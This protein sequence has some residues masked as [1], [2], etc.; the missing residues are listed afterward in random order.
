MP[1]LF[2]SSFSN[3][4]STIRLITSSFPSSI[5]TFCNL[6]GS[7]IDSK[8]VYS[9]SM[10]D[11]VSRSTVFYSTAV[12]LFYPSFFVI[13]FHSADSAAANSATKAASALL[14]ASSYFLRS[15]RVSDLFFAANRSCLSCSC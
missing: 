6:S 3:H 13:D 4:L 11:G 2:V 8:A 7:S 1:F 12:M 9:G 10:R 5:E 14:F 15:L